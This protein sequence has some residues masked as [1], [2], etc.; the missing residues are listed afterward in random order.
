MEKTSWFKIVISTI[1]ISCATLTILLIN[2]Q[3]TSWKQRL[4]NNQSQWRLSIE[5][6]MESILSE[7]NIVGNNPNSPNIKI[8]KPNVYNRLSSWFSGLIIYDNNQV[9]VPIIADIPQHILPKI[10]PSSINTN[11]LIHD[12]DVYLHKITEYDQNKI[13]VAKINKNYLWQAQDELH[14]NMIGCIVDNQD[15]TILCYD[16]KN[17]ILKNNDTI[18]K[19][20]SKLKI[21]NISY[22]QSNH[23]T[24]FQKTLL[25]DIGWN[26]NIIVPYSNIYKP[27]INI[28][29]TIML[30]GIIAL[31]IN[32]RRYKHDNALYKSMAKIIK[33][34]PFFIERNKNES[35]LNKSRLLEHYIDTQKNTTQLIK[36]L[37]NIPVH[38]QSLDTLIVRLSSILKHNSLK[39]YIGIIYSYNNTNSIYTLYNLKKNNLS[40]KELN[41]LFKTKEI[42]FD[43]NLKNKKALIYQYYISSNLKGAIIIDDSE[44]NKK[45]EFVH[46]QTTYTIG[47]KIQNWHENKSQVMINQVNK[48]PN[49]TFILNYL[50]QIL[51]SESNK[52]TV[53]MI[54]FNLDHTNI[55]GRNILLKISSSLKKNFPFEFKFAATI[56]HQLILAIPTIHSLDYIL[57]NLK[58]IIKNHHTTNYYIGICLHPDNGSQ[59]CNE[60][61]QRAHIALKEA[62]K[63]PYSNSLIMTNKKILEIKETQKIQILMNSAIQ[64]NEFTMLYQPQY[65]IHKNSISNAEAL[66][67]WPSSNISINLFLPLLEK[68]K[69]LNQLQPWIFNTVFNDLNIWNLSSNRKNTIAINLSPNQILNKNIIN[70]LITSI[71]AANISSSNIEIEIT[72]NSLISDPKTISK[73]LSKLKD[74]G[75]SIAIDD[76][77]TG[78]SSLQY[79]KNLPIDKIKIDRTFIREIDKNYNNFSITE[80][81]I[82][83]SNKLNIITVA[84]GV[85]NQEE[86]N[87]L[88]K[89]R[90]DFVQGY[91]ISKPVDIKDLL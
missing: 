77:G 91:Y 43:P 56:N 7:I 72:E 28:I 46:K 42:S 71:S 17:N 66:L 19:E 69:Q 63:Q 88:K 14:Q 36:S 76:F 70:Q 51:K 11:I 74:N 47:T 33:K 50:D 5:E 58:I 39:Q 45:N 23:N 44:E 83:L 9:S 68:S 20:N 61:I 86:F 62:S 22:I 85:E 80:S 37:N 52:V 32:Y 55:I 29:L 81:I 30:I 78:Y 24:S 10:Q 64:N 15:K 38:N 6:R 41:L 18:P 87:I 84:E 8:N 59:D 82:N 65:S 12:T 13:V 3:I 89:L 4:T 25:K 1:L 2:H 79:I 67:R 26:I 40:L 27:I 49:Q 54:D 21:N 48:L 73:T 16:S 35:L 53:I 31:L 75:I 34:L 57:T 60:L 90:C